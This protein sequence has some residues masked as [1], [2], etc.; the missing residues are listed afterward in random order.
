MTT[1]KTIRRTTKS[2][3]TSVTTITKS[4]QLTTRLTCGPKGR[5]YTAKNKSLSGAFKTRT[6]W[7][8]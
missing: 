4:G 2:G 5:T 8:S 7:P 3:K 6:A 1:T